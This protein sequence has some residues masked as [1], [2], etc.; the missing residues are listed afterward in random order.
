MLKIRLQRIGR[1]N[2]PAY[3]IVVTEAARAAKKGM[4]EKL[5]TY[6]PKTKE[7]S[8]NADRVKYWMSVGAKP[9]DT[10]HNMLV[11]LGVI[12]GKKINVLPKYVEPAKEE[13]PA[14]AAAP[15]AEEVP[16]EAP[17]AEEA[18]APEAAP[19]TAAEEAPAAEVA[20]AEEAK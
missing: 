3:R 9:S 7:R 11:S 10:M 2:S 17:A 16:A 14:E 12:S 19:E 13:A 1:I 6:N 18:P 15:A 4:I 20:P 8:L 5:G